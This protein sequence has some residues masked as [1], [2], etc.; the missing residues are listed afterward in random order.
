M[1]ETTQITRVANRPRACER[2]CSKVGRNLR[3]NQQAKFRSCQ[4]QVENLK[5]QSLR[6]LC[7]SR[8]CWLTQ[9]AAAFASL[10]SADLPS[11]CR[12]SP[13]RSTLAKHVETPGPQRCHASRRTCY[14]HKLKQR[15]KL[16]AQG[17]SA[18]KPPP[19]ALN[20]QVFRCQEPRRAE[21][22]CIA[23]PE[24]VSRPHIPASFGPAHAQRTVV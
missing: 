23:Q 21:V 6:L 18:Q 3:S 11:D 2:C 13:A 20:L 1:H 10:V 8:G 12:P 22:S 4:S 14:R 15:N 19:L 9:A 5:H 17:K 24:L 7:N 16:W